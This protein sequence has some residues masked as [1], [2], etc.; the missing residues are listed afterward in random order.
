MINFVIVGFIVGVN[1]II[2]FVSFIVKFWCFLLNNVN[3]V[4]CIKGISIFVFIVW[5]IC[6][7]IKILKFG[8]KV[9]IIEFNKNVFIVV[10]YKG[11]VLI[12]FIR[13]VVRGIMMLLISI[14]LVISYCDVFLLIFN[15]FIILG[16]VVFNNVWFKIV[17]NVLI[18]IIVIM[19]FCFWVVNLILV[20]IIFFF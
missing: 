19:K 13:Y 15:F 18:N 4:N 16:N 8:V 6:V 3:N 1:W 2:K 10:K 20:I 7:N 11:L 12:L 17:I 5:I 14:N 9:V